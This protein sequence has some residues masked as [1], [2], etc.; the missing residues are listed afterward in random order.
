MSSIG[1]SGA[2][3]YASLISVSVWLLAGLVLLEV[4]GLYPVLLSGNSI[5]TRFDIH[6]LIRTGDAGPKSFF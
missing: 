4:G 3:K 2:S 1:R 6:T 5:R